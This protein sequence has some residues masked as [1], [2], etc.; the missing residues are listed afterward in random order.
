MNKKA[1]VIIG[2]SFLVLLSALAVWHQSGD[3]GA[4]PVNANGYVYKHYFVHA[5]M[6]SPNGTLSFN[7]VR[8]DSI[9]IFMDRDTLVIDYPDRPDVRYP[10][11]IIPISVTIPVKV[12]TGTVAL[13]NLQPN[14]FY[15]VYGFPDSTWEALP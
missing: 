13:F 1:A 2:G 5:A 9:R 3:E 7:A 8:Q 14:K 10:G 6:S 15:S 12:N 11:V 4:E